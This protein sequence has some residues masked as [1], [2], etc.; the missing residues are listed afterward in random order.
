MTGAECAIIAGIIGLA[1]IFV[2][3][4]A[5]QEGKRDGRKAARKSCK[6]ELRNALVNAK[7]AKW[8][9]TADSTGAHSYF[10]M[11]NPKYRR[12]DVDFNS[13]WYW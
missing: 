6:D 10:R 5:Y 2:G 12:L 3:Y 11:K 8:E 13:G 7:L 1:V 9:V 4:N